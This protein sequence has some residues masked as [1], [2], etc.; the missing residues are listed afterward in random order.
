MRTKK[1]TK[2]VFPVA[3][4]GTR[5]LPAKKALSSDI[6]RRIR[7]LKI[8]SGGEYQLTDAI[9]SLLHVENV[10][11]YQ[12]HNTRYDCG[13]KFGFLKAA[14]QIAKKHPELGLNVIDS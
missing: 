12:L 4:L 5:F 3:G 13:D 6:F 1:I 2:A 7:E 11:A 14:I 9:E 8:G 10:M